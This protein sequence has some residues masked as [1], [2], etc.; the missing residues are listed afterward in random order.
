MQIRANYEK[1]I[2]EV[3]PKRGKDV[4][5]LPSRPEIVAEIG[6]LVSTLIAK[7]IRP[8]AV[9]ISRSCVSGYCPREYAGFIEEELKRALME[10]F[11]S[12]YLSPFPGT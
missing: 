10:G 1:V 3:S 5:H 8:A 4:S 12:A 2:L 7:K 9:T 6:T 11:R